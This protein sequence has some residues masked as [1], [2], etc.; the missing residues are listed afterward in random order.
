MPAGGPAYRAP[1]ARPFGITMMVIFQFLLGLAS[2]IFGGVVV[3]FMS[4]G[5]LSLLFIMGGA[6]LV[7]VGLLFLYSAIGMNNMQPWSWMWSLLA[8]IINILGYVFFIVAT[9][10]PPVYGLGQ[11]ILSLVIILYLIIPTTR[12]L[13]GH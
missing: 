3:F 4:E 5:S 12:V 13:F 2:L 6:A 10:M 8:H 1:G 9:G 7:I 11:M